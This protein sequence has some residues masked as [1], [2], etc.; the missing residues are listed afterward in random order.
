MSTPK[1]KRT[2]KF[3]DLEQKLLDLIPK[4]GTKVDSTS[5]IRDY[6]GEEAPFNARNIVVGRLRDIAAKAVHAHLPWRLRKSPRNG[7][8][9][10]LFWVE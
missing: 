10:I 2:I 4:D 1:Y 9:A 7:P 3:S 5:L 6:Y 8:N